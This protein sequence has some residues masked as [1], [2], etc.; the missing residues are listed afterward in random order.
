MSN[1]IFKNKKL[2][3]EKLLLF[4]FSIGN[5]IYTY[6][7]D[8]ADGQFQMIVTIMDDRTVSTKVVDSSLNEEYV[9]YRTPGACGSFVGMVRTDYENVLRE[10]SE[11]CFEQNVFKSDYAQKVIQYVRDT[12][13]DELEFLWQRFPDNAIFRRKDSNKWYG[14]L[15]VLPK[16]K[17]GLDSDEV[18]DVL[19][20]RINAEDIESVVDREKYFPGYHMNKKHWFT[21]C[22]DGSVLIDE[23]FQR[24]DTSYALAKK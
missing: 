3:L 2:N 16:N 20:L 24:I 7:T 12:Y 6:T 18:I 11:K 10:I 23:I 14:A 22:L 15:L 19:D 17:L 4:G 9:L 5:G 8:I 1:T 13:H 21:I